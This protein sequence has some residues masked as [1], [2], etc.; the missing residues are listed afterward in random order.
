[1][2]G[3]V[4]NLLNSITSLNQRDGFD[5][6]HFKKIKRLRYS[7]LEWIISVI[8]D[9]PS[10]FGRK[11]A[12]YKIGLIDLNFE[13]ISY[14]DNDLGDTDHTTLDVTD[15]LILINTLSPAYLC[16]Y[17]QNCRSN[18]IVIPILY[19]CSAKNV[20]HRAALLII[21]DRGEVYLIDPN[22]HPKYFNQI[23]GQDTVTTI[24]SAFIQYLQEVKKTG[25]KLKY[26]SVRKWNPNNL[27]LNR[28]FKETQIGTGHCVVL[29]L[30]LI[31]LLCNQI[32]KPDEAYR[33]LRSLSDNELLLVISAYTRGVITI[34][35]F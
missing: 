21:R 9:Q 4:L 24:E 3:T 10:F 8:N 13:L 1:M 34:I 18:R 30:I 14:I 23:L 27:V 29:T 16:T 33:L 26:I 31:H 2:L 22:G 19:G 20:N 12:L 15:N 11:H 7:Q 6:T 35:R 5:K 28:V 25:L 32:D 17:V